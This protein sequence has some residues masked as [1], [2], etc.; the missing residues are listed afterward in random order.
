MK[1]NADQLRKYQGSSIKSQGKRNAIYIVLDAYNIGAIF[2]LA[3][4]VAA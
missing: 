1:L 2:R 4:A 3:D